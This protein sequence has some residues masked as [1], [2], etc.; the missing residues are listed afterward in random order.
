MKSYALNSDHMHYKADINSMATLK[1]IGMRL[2]SQGT[3]QSRGTKQA[4]R[5]RDWI[6][7]FSPDSLRGEKSHCGKHCV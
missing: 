5:G 1:K 2:P 4:D 6:G 3:N 7:I